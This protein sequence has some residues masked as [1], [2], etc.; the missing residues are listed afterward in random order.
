MNIKDITILLANSINQPH[1]IETYLRKVY[2]VGYKIGYEECN[3][4]LNKWVSID[5]EKPKYYDYTLVKFENGE[6]LFVWRAWSESTESDIYTIC[7]TNIIA[8]SNPVEWK[9]INYR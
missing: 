5:D 4:N 3:K 7:G 9:Q 1:V 2:S 6:I 8:D